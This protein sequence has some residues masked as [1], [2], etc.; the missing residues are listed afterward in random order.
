[1]ATIP[2]LQIK[3]ERTKSILAGH[4]WIFSGA[5]AGRPQIPDGSLVKVQSHSQV[6]GI[7]YYNSHTDI[8]VRMLSM[9]DVPIDAA[10]FAERFALLRRRK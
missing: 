4:P 2:V 6:L 9:R 7:G 10:F 3:P 8:A 1:M 5:L